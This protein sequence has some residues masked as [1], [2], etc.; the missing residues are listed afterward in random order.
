M[1]S[2]PFGRTVTARPPTRHRGGLFVLG[3]YPSALHVR[4]QAPDGTRIAALAVDDE[5]V[6]FWDGDDQGERIDEWKRAVGFTPA[7]GHVEPAG[8]ANGSSGRWVDEQILTPL[9]F[10]RDQT[11]IT[12]CLD[13][14]RAGQAQAAAIAQRFVPFAD[15]VGLDRPDLPE[16]PSE[17]AIVREAITDH[18]ERLSAE[19]R[20]AEPTTIVTLGN[21]ALRVLRELLPDT[22]VVEPRLSPQRY[23]RRLLVELDGRPVAWYPLVHP[24]GRGPVKQA[25]TEWTQLRSDPD[26][27]AARGECPACGGR[28]LV[29]ILWGLPSGDVFDDV[30]RGRIAIGGCIVSGD[31]PDRYC[32]ECGSNVYPDGSFEV[33]EW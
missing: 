12:D 8:P 17:S 28:G 24:G 3:A 7:W 22:D 13:T 25:H 5:P 10:R 30:R 6:P 16:H 27:V 14:Y 4:W 26:A 21:A 29:P 32:I 11:W 18:F 23:G 33:D 1:H 31:D 9:G 19:L 2:Y 15:R 20:H